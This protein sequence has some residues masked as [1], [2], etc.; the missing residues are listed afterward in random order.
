MAPAKVVSVSLFGSKGKYLRGAEKLAISIKSNL[1]GWSLVFFVGKSVPTK[2]KKSLT[3]KNA[4]L[5]LVD[6]PENLSASA[7]RFRIWE[8]G[9]PEYVLFRDSDSIVSSREAQAVTQWI[10]SGVPV[11]IIRDHPFHSSEKMAGLWGLRPKGM[12][13]FANEV[14]G[15][16]F[17]DSYGSD[18]A[19]LATRVYPRIVDSSL[20]HASF[21][22][23]EPLTQITEFSKGSSRIGTFCGE[24][25]T[26]SLLIRTYA[27]LH[28]L[29]GRKACDCKK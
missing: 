21:H 7:W 1:P 16:F 27:R 29:F 25:V 4:T 23:H 28:R 9:N 11:H 17:L 3:A 13:W 20:V 14:R 8:L 19:F 15:H 5:I 18:Q 26:S 24:S 10:E 12:Q 22:R 6:E 2:I